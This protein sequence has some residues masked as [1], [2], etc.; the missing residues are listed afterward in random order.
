MPTAWTHTHVV[1][2]DLCIAGWFLYLVQRGCSKPLAVSHAAKDR[3]A[4]LVR[5]C[6]K[7]RDFRSTPPSARRSTSGRDPQ[8]ENEYSRKKIC[9]V[10][11]QRCGNMITWRG[12]RLVIAIPGLQAGWLWADL[13]PSPPGGLGVTPPGIQC[14]ESHARPA[15]SFSL[16][17]ERKPLWPC[18]NKRFEYHRG[19][20][21]LI[22]LPLFVWLGSW[23]LRGI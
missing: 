10:W 1:T 3:S 14:S 4:F 2:V 13:G 6:W 17:N 12:R 21:A 22:D 18:L 5:W 16:W 7:A 9:S 23:R 19:G 15:T 11:I 8:P 20:I